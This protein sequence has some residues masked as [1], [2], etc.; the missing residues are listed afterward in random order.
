MD[1]NLDHSF[2]VYVSEQKR[3]GGKL[4]WA[5][6]VEIFLVNLFLLT[7]TPTLLARSGGKLRW[8]L[9]VEIFLVSLFSLTA[10]PTL[11]WW[12]FR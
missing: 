8:A 6:R 12:A 1:L 7:A 3:Y 11:Q 9:Q 5:L 4:R 2:I 10:I